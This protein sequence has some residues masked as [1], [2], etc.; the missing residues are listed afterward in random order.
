MR[1]F[2]AALLFCCALAP[3]SA[4]A[5][6][7]KLAWE[8]E[9]R[10]N[11]Y[12]PPLTADFHPAP[13]LETVISDSEARTL[14]CVAA[15]GTEL[16]A[17][18]G[19]WKK[20]LISAAA[21][22]GP[23]PDG[24]RLLALGNGDG[25]LVCLNA[26]D[27]AVRWRAQPG[28]VEWGGGLWADLDGDGVQE[29]VL[30]TQQDGVAAFTAAGAPLWT[31]RGAEG[32]PPVEVR[33]PLAALDLDGDGRASLF[34]AGR[35]GF[36]CLNPDGALRWE[37][38]TGDDFNSA[39]TLVRLDRDAA[40]SALAQSADDDYLW[41]FDAD[42]GAPRWKA[43]LQSGPDAY[44]GSSLAVGDLDG[45]G[46]AE[47]I[48]G[49]RA[50]HLHAVNADG[51]L[52]WVFQT[53]KP[54]HIAASVGDVTGDGRPELL[55]ASGDHALYCLD[56]NGR[57]LWRWNTGLRLIHP[58]TLADVDGDGNTDI[59]VCGSDRILRRLVPGGRHNP[60]AMPWPSRRRDTAQTGAAADPNALPPRVANT[61][62]LPV[63][64]GFEQGKVRDGL[65]QFDTASPF[66]QT[67][68]SRPR[69]WRAANPGNDQW[70]IA[71]DPRGGGQALRVLGA[72]DLLSDFVPLPPE[73]RAVSVAVSA[74]HGGGAT[75]A[76]V[77]GGVPG[78]LREEALPESPATPEGWSRFALENAPRPA[79][80]T[81]VHLRLR[82]PAGGETFWD[83]AEMTGSFLEPA[84]ARVLVNQAGYDTGA[85][86]A[87]VVQANFTAA[88]AR[89]AVLDEHG[90]TVAEGSL[91]APGR[92]VGA[93]GSDWGHEYYRQDFSPVDAPGRYRVRVTLDGLEAESWPF[94][95]APDRLWNA[96]ARL[97]Y[98]F[99]WYQ[100]CG[101]EIPGFHGACHLDDSVGPDGKTQ[102]SV[103]GGWHD[104][105]DYNKYHN[106]PY[107]HGIA[108][109]YG[110][111][112]AAFDAL[113][114]G[115]EE[116]FWQE[117]LWGGEH[118]RRMVMD[119][120][121]S[122]GSITSGYGF[123][124]PPELETD[125]LP[126]TGDER[127][128][129]RE[130]GDNPDE[131]QAALARMAA[132]MKEL[133]R[134]DP[135]PWAE[136]AARSLDYALREGRRGWPQLS[137]AVDLFAATGEE[138]FAAAARELAGELLVEGKMD[139]TPMTV[140]TARRYDRAFGEDHSG[141]LAE[142]LAK[143]ADAMLALARN[144]FGVCAFGSPDAPNFF[145]TP[146]DKG[147]WHVGTN[148]HL[149][150]SAAVVA[151]ALQYRDNPAW[152]G[153]VQDQFNWVLGLN[154]YDTSLMEGVGSA[155]PPSYH[156]RY[157][158]SGVPRGAVPG[159]VINGI[160]WRAVGDDRPSLDLS[161]VDI[162][163][164][165]SNECWLPH[166]TAFLN[167]IAAAYSGR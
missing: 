5:Q 55:A 71:E 19:G 2:R 140:D 4:A 86:K 1:A 160:T 74:R 21:L 72:N 102:F 54:V 68:M 7:P 73:L 123:W 120:G 22:S 119:D 15:D 116:G 137:A 124:G 127:P 25:S 18:D 134:D 47:I 162:P 147:G 28:P 145:G 163:A 13:G 146:A 128:A 53:V 42:T 105:G 151:L 67:I 167:A 33:G 59:L 139:F 114:P 165:E 24:G 87:F 49:S 126:G 70:R 155:F 51:T 101:M 30:A 132:L 90:E 44:S 131:H 92:I 138:R 91:P 16:W 125:N 152:R 157:V 11:L 95:I 23:M 164:Y 31:W 144:P 108:R 69:G 159:S 58:P 94:E 130:R 12:A 65:E 133:G 98:R 142:G 153:F 45:D 149:M 85:P 50:G 62:P 112:P 103:A 81:H 111:R 35:W 17:I 32:A 39:V 43:P 115:G 80:A 60:A 75:A 156:H 129:S 148:S 76:L 3:L 93:Y 20:R 82:S 141:M 143:K 83:D 36:F 113:R 107:L 161:G 57:E 78:T 84:A 61:R 106:A 121:S 10:S 97:G 40:W 99:F 27:G 46:V 38:L 110:M 77:W 150:E 158:F 79:N 41:C 14:R 37:H 89:Y 48:A 104:A 100:R 166:N 52:R 9:A 135:A 29:F 66:Y 63:F 26:A 117:I 34:G 6:P 118:V 136:P 154:P 8:F 88:D 109:A 96:A 122:F 56:G 64:G